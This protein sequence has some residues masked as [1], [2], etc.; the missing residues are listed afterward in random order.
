MNPEP[1]PDVVLNT[2]IIHCDGTSVP[3]PGRIGI[4]AV[5]TAPDGTRHSLSRA[6]GTYGCNNE[7]EACALIA[8]LQALRSMG[9][10]EGASLSIHSDSSILI[11]QLGTPHIAAIARLAHVFDE[12]RALLATF[13]QVEL[14]WIPRRRNS[15]ADTLARAALGLP[16]KADLK[17]RV[18]KRYAR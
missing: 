6:T 5:L 14:H 13:S 4:G 1:P 17:P 15:E 10:A 11:A 12:A 2:W 9:V 3:N 7:A 16:G 8:A 18:K